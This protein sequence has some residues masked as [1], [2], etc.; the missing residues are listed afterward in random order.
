V[1]VAALAAL[2]ADAT[3][4]EPDERLD[5]ADDLAAR[6]RAADLS[7][8][9]HVIGKRG[10]AVLDMSTFPAA[11]AAL[12]QGRSIVLMDDDPATLDGMREILSRCGASVQ[13]FG[14][15]DAGLKA[16]DEM[17]AL[18]LLIAENRM[19]DR[20]GYDVFWAA[21]RRFP[22]LPVILTTGFGYDPHHSIVRASQEGLAGI[23]FKPFEAARLVEEAARALSSAGE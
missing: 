6:L 20:P 19:G 21:R 4:D 8:R 16:L 15:A 18:D 11:A 12:L 9:T 1:E 14:T 13:G 23:L 7:R 22:G 2:I 5:S 3:E 10:P 17:E